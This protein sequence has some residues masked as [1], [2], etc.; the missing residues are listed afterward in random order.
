MKLKN[1]SGKN[2]FTLIEL[3]VVIAIIAI[4]AAMLLPA[5]ARAKAKAKQA[6]C[7]NNNKEL[8]LAL[9]MYLGDFQQYPGD[10]APPN[11][12]VWMT[13]L[14]S[15]M[16]KNRNAFSC[17]AAFADAM[18]DTNNNHTLGGNGEDN[19]YSAW[20]V[21]PSS[22]FSIGYNDWGLYLQHTP[23]LGLGGDVNNNNN[24][25]HGP[26][27]DS[28][29]RRPSDMIAMGD[30]KS[31]E[32]AGLLANAF[33]ANLDPTAEDFGHT[34]WPSNRHNYSIDF[35]FADAH[36]ETTKRVTPN[37]GG[38]V[39]PTDS[40]WRRRWNN[41]D[42]SHDGTEGDNVPTW[43]FSAAASQLDPSQ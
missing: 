23:Q 25:Y 9:V 10:Y 8:G 26:V 35:L 29:I 22:R 40:T 7:M 37:N 27:K 6:S 3:L 42:L 43:A 18:W 30:V 13:R 34:Q 5:L 16:G 33:S 11:C 15:L 41:D 1:N 31:S 24:F 12:Y 38:P 14:Y 17:P 21:T 28:N 19:V 4:L 20:T 36:V 2:A 39:S 32:V